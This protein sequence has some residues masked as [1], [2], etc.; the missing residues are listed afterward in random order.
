MK[1]FILLSIALISFTSPVLAQGPETTAKMNDPDST[2]IEK[3]ATADEYISCFKYIRF[4]KIIQI[5]KDS[6]ERK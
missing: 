2:V 4:N 3:T 5:H 1:Y 6:Y